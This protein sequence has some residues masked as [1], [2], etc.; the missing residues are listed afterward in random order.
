M[1]IT[2]KLLKG[3]N[4]T[5]EQIDTIIEAHTDIVDRLKSDLQKYKDDAEKLVSVQDEL[6]G[7]KSEHGDNYKEKYEKVKKEFDQYKADQT[8]KETRSAKENAV[9]HLMKDVGISEKRLD[10][11]LKVYDFTG[12]ELD[13][14]GALKDADA[15]KNGIKKDW[16]DFIVT[17][18]IEGAKTANPPANNGGSTMTKADIYKKDEHGRYVMTAAERQKAL[19]EN[20][21][22]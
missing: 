8:E 9:R 14:N 5:D 16:S 12:V 11:I 6:N 22:M 20:N 10:S 15:L 17:Q 19:I 18:S 1:A 3:M 2:R 21:I 4:L 13:E 7:L